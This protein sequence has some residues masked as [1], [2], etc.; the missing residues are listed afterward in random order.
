MVDEIVL[1]V[2]VG[3]F[4]ELVVMVDLLCMLVLLEVV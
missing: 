3:I 2:V 1:L 4:E